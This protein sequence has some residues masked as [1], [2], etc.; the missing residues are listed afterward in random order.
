MVPNA[1]W[2]QLTPPLP[3]S[4]YAL[5]I[6]GDGTGMA[7]IYTGAFDDENF[8]N[9]HTG[10]G[11]LAMANQG[12]NTNGCQVPSCWAIA[13]SLFCSRIRELGAAALR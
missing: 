11:V 13:P 10:P 6:Q 2:L 8:K 1:V 7:S 5:R 3:R 12:A 9:L 4:Y